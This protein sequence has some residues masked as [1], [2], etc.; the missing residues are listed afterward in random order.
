M[1]YTLPGMPGIVPMRPSRHE[2]WRWGKQHTIEFLIRL[3][4]YWVAYSWFREVEEPDFSFAAIPLDDISPLGGADPS[5]SGYGHRSHRCGRDVDIYN[6]RTDRDVSRGAST[7]YSLSPDYDRE[8]NVQLGV[9][10][11]TAAGTDL[12][13]VIHNDPAVQSAMTRRAEAM[14]LTG[15]MFLRDN[16][17]ITEPGAFHSHDNHFH[18]RLVANDPQPC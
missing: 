13:L 12:V 3:T 11:V 6:I 18:V 8:L 15:A 10:I 2:Q 7:D 5:Q 1:Y 4:L 9:A 17:E 16:Q 14:G